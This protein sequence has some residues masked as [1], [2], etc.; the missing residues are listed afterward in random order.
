[1]VVLSPLTAEFVN[2]RILEGAGGVDIVTVPE[3]P[4]PEA[5][6]LALA[7]ADLVLADGRHKHR[8]DREAL[9]VMSRCRLIQQPAVGFDAIDHRSAADF[10]IPVANAAGYNRD[11]VADW[12]IM[13][14]L[15]LIRQGSWADREMRGPDP[16]PYGRI[17]GRELGALT[18][19]IVGL[20]NVGSSVATRLRAFGTRLLFTDVVPRSLPGVELVALNE[21]LDRSDVVTVHVPL[22]HDTRGLIG[23]E[24]IARMK[25][26]AILINASR[27]PVVDEAAVIQSLEQ[28]RLGGA[29]LDVFDVEPLPATS[30]LR[31]F[32][33]V[34]LSPHAGGLTTE[35]R[36]RVLQ[37][38]GVNLRRVLE[39]QEPF[40]VVNGVTK[41]R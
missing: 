25:P 21:L 34:F 26:G 5:V 4:A 19:G 2:D 7:G 6:R 41:H 35:A 1:L 13:A 10:G 30:P 28:G 11:A 12:V 15:N 27:G 14:I 8:I 40:N 36:E 32:P 37:I 17:S 38:C 29:G 3:P 24:A 18:V 23:S 33:N 20:G 16:W 9:R 31:R 39:G 22:D